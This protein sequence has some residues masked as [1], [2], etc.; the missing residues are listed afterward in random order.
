MLLSEHENAPD[1][2]LSLKDSIDQSYF[3]WQNSTDPKST[4]LERSL[5][6]TGLASDSVARLVRHCPIAVEHQFWGYVRHFDQFSN[7]T[8]GQVAESFM[9]GLLI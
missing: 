4:S 3:L 6:V 1:C 2:S 8:L 9:F 5:N 7:A